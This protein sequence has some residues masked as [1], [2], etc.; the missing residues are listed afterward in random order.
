MCCYLPSTPKYRKVLMMFPESDRVLFIVVWLC[1]S[2]RSIPCLV[3]FR[4]CGSGALALGLWSVCCGVLRYAQRFGVLAETGQQ[5]MNAPSYSLDFGYCNNHRNHNCRSPIT[6]TTGRP[7]EVI[8]FKCLDIE[9]W[10]CGGWSHG[11]PGCRNYGIRIA[12]F[13][14]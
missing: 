12:E 6:I 3:L 9:A 7:V 4:T 14:S 2:P 5:L 13:A 11:L 8:R 1:S 10:D